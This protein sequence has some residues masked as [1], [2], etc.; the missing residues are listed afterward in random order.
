MVTTTDSAVKQFISQIRDLYEKEPDVDKRW[1]KMIPVMR[2]LLADEDARKDSAAWPETVYTDRAE[3]LL[4]YED[5]DYGFVLNGFIKISN[6]DVKPKSLIHDHAQNWTLYGVL[7]GTDAIERYER[8]DDGSKPDYAEV[9]LTGSFQVGPGDVDLVR[10]WL[11]HAEVGETKRTTAF[12]LR[13][14]R[15]GSFLQGRYN[16]E[17]NEYWQGYGPRMTPYMLGGMDSAPTL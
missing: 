2:E 16:P 14:E 3:N 13:A 9:K 5:P 17:T 4:F 12:I 11:I 6:P 10:P 1:E 8:V 15:P 7:D